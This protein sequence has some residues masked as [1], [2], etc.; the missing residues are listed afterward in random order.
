MPEISHFPCFFGKARNLLHLA[1]AMYEISYIVGGMMEELNKSIT[2]YL[3]R[4]GMA[5]STFGRRVLGDGNFL[6]GLRAGRDLRM[7]TIRRV[8]QFMA[9]NPDGI[10]A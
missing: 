5:E 6:R 1:L 2:D 3:A 4:T 7:S 10:A 8:Q 9:D